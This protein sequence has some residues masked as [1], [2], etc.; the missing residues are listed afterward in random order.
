MKFCWAVS[1]ELRWRT[2]WCSIFKFRQI[3]SS[4]KGHYSQKIW[5]RISCGYAHLH[6]KSFINTKFHEILLSGFRGV[7]LTNC[8]RSIF[9]LSQISKFK[10]G[11][12][13]RKK[14][15][16]KFPVEMHIYTLCHSKLQ[17]FTKFC[18]AVSEELRWQTV[19]VVSFI[20]AKF[21]S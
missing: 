14:I 16:S 4:K 11:V 3:S 7:S 2:V 10:K 5:I 8:F 19:S 21:I 13:T 9:H 18:W 15:E 1:V 12:I 17:S 6:I 20:F